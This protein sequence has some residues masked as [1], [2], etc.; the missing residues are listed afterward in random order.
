MAADLDECENEDACANGKCLNTAGSYHCFCSLP[1]VL[2]ATRNRCVNVSNSAGEC[3]SDYSAKWSL[4][5]G[6]VVPMAFLFLSLADDE[7]ELDIHLDIC[8]QSVSNYI[9][10]E[11]LL[12]QRTTYTECCCRYGDA[13][14]QDCALCPPRSSGEKEQIT[15]DFGRSGVVSFNS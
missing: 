12:G 7:D 9:C 11:P 10:N 3:S 15:W 1:L 13:W 14:S 6:F 5:A 2:D 8:W 4:K